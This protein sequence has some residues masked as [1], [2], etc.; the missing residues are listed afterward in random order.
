MPQQ[1]GTIEIDYGWKKL[2]LE[3]SRMDKSHADV[4]IFSGRGLDLAGIAYYALVNEF[5]WEKDGVVRIPERSF[6]RATVDANLPKYE[7]IIQYQC[8]Q[9]EIGK[10]TVKGGLTILAI[11]V[12]NDIKRAITDFTT[13]GNAPSTIKKK[14]VDNPLIDSDA[15]WNAVRHEVHVP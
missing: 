3:L 10:Q 14:G 9:I 5:G 15:M 6:V 4:G 13:P 2:T 12:Q 11:E 1:S 8:H 7:A